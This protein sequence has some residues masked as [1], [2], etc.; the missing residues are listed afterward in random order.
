[1]DYRDY[2]CI[3]DGSIEQCLEEIEVGDLEEHIYYGPQADIM[4]KLQRFNA[5]HRAD[6]EIT[7]TFKW[8][9]GSYERV[10]E[11]M[12]RGLGFR[13]RPSGMYNYLHREDW[14]RTHTWDSIK[15]QL[16]DMD[17]D[18]YRL[19][20]NGE[21]WLDDPSVLVERKNLYSNYLIEKVELADEIVENVDIMA[22]MYHQLFV[23]PT[24]RS[25]RRYMLLTVLRITPD[26]MK[27]YV[28]E[29]RNSNEP[30]KHI[31]NIACDT[32][33][34]LNLITYPLQVMTRHS[35]YDRPSMDVSVF[36]QV[37]Q[38]SDK[39]YLAFPYI[40]GSRS[41]R[42]GY[43]GNSVC[44]GDQS[45]DMHNSLYRYDLPSFVLQCIPW[46]TSYTNET[47]PH[48]NIKMMYHGEPSRLSEEYRTIFGTNR[49]DMCTYIPDGDND[50]CDVNECALRH[51]CTLYKNAHPQ[52]VTPEQAE[53]MTLQWATRM[54]G[55]NHAAPT[56]IHTTDSSGNP[57]SVT[58]DR[59]SMEQA[60]D[61][62]EPPIQG[63]REQWDPEEISQTVNDMVN[64]RWPDESPQGDEM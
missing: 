6:L 27:V 47:Q 54:G 34:Y 48:S 33:V 15:S 25:S 13:R 24:S 55:V 3:V 58:R 1:M 60:A 22:E 32:D 17:S 26:V 5:R 12:M 41:Y 52:P 7:K 53:Q 44:F 2:D 62:Q 46:A 36:G 31:E 63:D 23:H 28:T 9:R 20:N 42:G 39:G 11:L 30:A 8:K 59:T 29:G 4:E 16:Q 38:P 43:F 51:S 64:E 57:I 18:L 35:N 61:A 21:V 49:S 19:R 10:A 56:V 37:E 50:Y 45:T 40:S 14:F